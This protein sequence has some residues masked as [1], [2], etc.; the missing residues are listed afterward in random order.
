[1]AS[2]SI[3]ITKWSL[4]F[5]F[6]VKL[7][8]D[9]PLIVFS[10]TDRWT[11]KGNLNA[12]PLLWWGIELNKN[13]T[14]FITDLAINVTLINYSNYWQLRQKL[15]RVCYKWHCTFASRLY[16]VGWTFLSSH[17]DIPKNANC[18]FQKFKVEYSILE[19]K[20][21]VHV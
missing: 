5:S 1:M 17:I 4:L 16:S 14:K 15:L 11:D 6:S 13:G 2:Y 21:A 8:L 10:W 7:L 9:S 12:T 3:I 20:L 18:Q 19:K